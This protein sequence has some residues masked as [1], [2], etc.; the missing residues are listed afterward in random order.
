MSLKKNI[1]H[2]EQLSKV[3]LEESERLDSLDVVALFLGILI[4][5]KIVF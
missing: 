4:K 3:K 2:T 1:E 5:I